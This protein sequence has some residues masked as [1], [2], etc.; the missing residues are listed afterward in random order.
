MPDSFDCVVL[1][2]GP[3][4]SAA[5]TLVAEAG[6]KTLLLE[7]DKMPR[8]HVGESLMPESYWP[9]KRLGV[10]DQ[11]KASSHPIKQ[12]VQFVSPTGQASAPFYF[13]QHDPR[14]C[15]QTWQVVRDEFDHM[16]FKNAAAKGADCRDETRVVEVLFENNSSR[17][18]GVRIVAP[19]GTHEEI[20]ASVVIDATGQQ[21]LVASRLGIRNEDP[22]MRKSSIWTYYEGAERDP[23]I[24]AGA[25]IILLTENKQAW[26][27][28]IPL[29]GGITSIGVVG[30]SDYLLKGRGQPAA[31]FEE[32][33][34]RC[35]ALSKRL[36][37]ACRSQDFHVAREFSYKASQAAGD[38]WVLIG[39][40]YSFIDPV[41]S[42]GVYFAL[43]TAELAADCVIEGL[44][45]NDTSANQLGSWANQFDT[46]ANLVRKLVAAFY[47]NGFSFGKFIKSHPEHLGNLTDLLIGRIFHPEANRIFQD[48]DPWIAEAVLSEKIG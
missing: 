11:L 15:S 38:G 47:T 14:E 46:A 30:D 24:D 26:F 34:D 18:C 41:Y 3:A 43:K 9:L 25:T 6:F 1:G 4:G 7:R 12:S 8:F 40:A 42:S 2:A 36:A 28:F 5:A 31:I 35:P 29:S 32:E 44:R 22:N 33:L 27:W 45:Q 20:D 39:D 21:S 16:L 37:A 48:M 13:Q 23:G 10:L 19:E 17:A